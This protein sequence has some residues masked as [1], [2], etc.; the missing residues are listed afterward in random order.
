MSTYKLYYWDGLQGR[1]EYI[2]LALEAA[3]APY[4]DVARQEGNLFIKELMEKSEHPSFAPPFVDDGGQ[5]IGQMPAI[6]LHLG[7]KLDLAPREPV[8]RMWTHQIQLTIA[9]FI[10][11]AHDVHHPIGM[12]S[13][14]EDQKPEALRRAD[15]F[16]HA[17]VPKY[18]RWFES[19]L[20]RNTA[21]PGH[22][23]GD[24]L[25][26]ADLSLFQVVEGMSFAFPNLMA[27][28]ECDYPNMMGLH[29]RVSALPQIAEY[30]RSE[31]RLP[32]NNNDIFRHYPELDV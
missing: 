23:V 14:Y 5:T 8:A 6:L 21:G 1:G 22:L 9:D 27:R 11:E 3:G 16:C 4:I 18:F 24:R 15:E 7:D 20:A 13:Y 17:R 26:Y 10:L 2:R 30:L 25:S 31:R 12:G 28:V 29:G 32:P 19:V